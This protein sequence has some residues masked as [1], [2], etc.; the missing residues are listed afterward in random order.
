MHMQ[1][2][3]GRILPGRWSAFEAAYKEAIARRGEVMG[4]KVQWLLRDQND[5]DAGYSICTHP[6]KAADGGPSGLGDAHRF[7][8]RLSSLRHSM[9]RSVNPSVA[10]SSVS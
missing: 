3:W 6:A 4:L 10:R 1:V 7:W 9:P 8:S 5:P 2:V